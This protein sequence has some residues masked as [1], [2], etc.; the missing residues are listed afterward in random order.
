[1]RHRFL[2]F[3]AWV[4][5]LALLTGCG[6]VA[7]EPA[8]PQPEHTVLPQEPTEVPSQEQTPE[9]FGLPY[10]TTGG[11]NP[12]TCTDL[13]NRTIQ[14]L[15]FESLFRVDAGFEPQKQ[16][17]LDYTVSG[18]GRTHTFRLMPDAVFS[19]GSAITA[20]DV[21]ASIQAA[22]GSAY[23]GSR[24]ARVTAVTAAATDTVTLTTDTAFETLATL[25]DMPIVKAGTTAQSLPLGSGPF[26]ADLTGLQLRRNANW[27]QN[28][29]SLVDLD[30]IRLVPADIPTDVRDQFEYGAVNLVCADPNGN[31]EVTYHSDFELWSSNTTIMQYIGFNLNSSIFSIVPLRKAITYAIDREQLL[32]IGASDFAAATT[33]PVSPFAAT[34]NQK[35]AS[36][37]DYNPAA[38]QDAL[39]ASQIS[40]LVGG[41]GILD[42][43]TD[44]GTQPLSGRMLVCSDSDQRVRMAQCIADALGELGMDLTVVSLPR[45]SYLTA[46]QAGNFD[47]YYGEVRLPPNFD[48]SSFFVSGGSLSFGGI[49]DETAAQLCRSTLENSGN[50]YDLY[51]MILDR[52]LLCPVLFKTYAVY[53]TR[54]R[55]PSL[56]PSLDCVFSRS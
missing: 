44:N 8:A 21:V 5:A 48:L 32:G 46:L 22:T 39:R 1:M 40:D 19:D 13:T 25:L 27:W 29:T 12:Y 14:S 51:Q 31:A 17:C 4:L 50:A 49:A 37:Y 55:L 16:L 9:T 20:A 18:D 30:T 36:S 24:L 47:L 15:L 54:G 35:L 41:D 10:S 28:T 23:Y 56:S 3:F 45:Q 53:A 52:G 42:M 26:V 6:P 38:F 34:Y 33:L 43:Y 7:Q 11:M 2:Q